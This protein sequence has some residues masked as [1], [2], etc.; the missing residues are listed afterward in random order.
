MLKDLKPFVCDVKERHKAVG[1]RSTEPLCFAT[2]L[3]LSIPR[4]GRHF[5]GSW[6]DQGAD[7]RWGSMPA[8]GWSAACGGSA[9]VDVCA[10]MAA[11]VVV[12][13]AM[14]DRHDAE[15]LSNA[16]VQL[17]YRVYSC[18]TWACNR[19]HKHGIYA[20][21]ACATHSRVPDRRISCSCRRV[22][23]Q[24]ACRLA[25]RFTG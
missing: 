9:S 19:T 20:C 6:S 2:S 21:N 5:G 7:H 11:A 10:A 25:L 15:Q 18:C 3:R 12:V 4:S 24:S 8:L 17:F 23:E 14:I 22:R 13:H 16:L 1:A